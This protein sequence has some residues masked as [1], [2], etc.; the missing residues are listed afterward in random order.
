MTRG[1]S[2]T[3]PPLL[4]LHG[5]PGM[6]ETALFRHFNSS[7]ERHFTCVYWEQRGAGKSY[8]RHIRR[9]TMTVE[10]FLWDLDAVVDDVRRRLDAP[11]VA[12]FGH[13]WG[14][15]LGVL[16]A[17]RHPEKVSVYAGAGQIGDWPAA[18]RAS[19]A[20]VLDEARRNHHVKALQG[21]REIGPPPHNGDALWT[22]RLWLSHFEG[23][24]DPHSIWE[25]AQVLLG[26]AEA[27][28][29]ELPGLMRGLRFSLGA[30]WPEVSRLDLPKLAPELKMPVF[31]LLGR[32]DHWVPAQTSVAYFDVLKAPLK[33]LV[34]FERSGH[35]PFM[36]EPGHF[37]AAMINEVLPAARGAAPAHRPSAAREFAAA[38][39]R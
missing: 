2:V 14:S 32:R 7:L 13:S 36:D 30:M 20:F 9:S 15:A 8:D 11:K 34:W 29:L 19:Y 22:Q 16:Y 3:N 28:L 24:T 4:L 10:Q 17:A 18:E 12:L 26:Q 27:S 21:L 1:E 25:L 5:G 37:N 6:S 31:F 35:E 39:A 33:K 23:R 38:Q